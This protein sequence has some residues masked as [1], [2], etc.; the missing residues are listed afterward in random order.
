MSDDVRELHPPFT[1]DDRRKLHE[2]HAA[3]VELR[4]LLAPLA[5]LLA[6]LNGGGLNPAAAALVGRILRG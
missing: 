4:D 2:A 1:A 6:S 5:P 3:I